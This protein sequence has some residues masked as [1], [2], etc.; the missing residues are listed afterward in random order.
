MAGTLY[1]LDHLISAIRFDIA[2]AAHSAVPEYTSAEYILDARSLVPLHQPRVG[3]Y[4]KGG[5]HDIPSDFASHWTTQDAS[6]DVEAPL[7]ATVE[8]LLSYPDD[9][10]RRI[11][12]RAASRGLVAAIQA[13]D[14]FKYALSNAWGAKDKDGE[15]FSYVC[16]DSV[17]N[18]ER[19]ANGNAR[20]RHKPDAGERLVSRKPTF[21]CKGS[22]GT[23]FSA[24]G[25][26]V[27]VHYRHIAVHEK[28]A[29]QVRRVKSAE[30]RSVGQGDERVESGLLQQLRREEA[31]Y[32]SPPITAAEQRAV[33][34]IQSNTS[35]PLKRKYDAY[36]A[37]PTQQ[38]PRNASLADLLKQDQPNRPASS[39]SGSVAITKPQTTVAYELPSWLP[40]AMPPPPPPRPR[41]MP[42]RDQQM[43]TPAHARQS[44]PS[45]SDAQQHGLD[46]RL[47]LTWHNP[48]SGSLENQ[49]N[50]RWQRKI[51]HTMQAQPRGQGLF[52]TLKSRP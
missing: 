29:L 9:G 52:M 34:P 50:H 36:S 33:P 23:K 22:I 37:P 45:N 12:Q 7:R 15:R 28:A 46:P 43:R 1:S 41:P 40:T 8:A 5:A 51:N 13:V 44:Q 11:V 27:V 14:G 38:T 18:K 2:A 47:S 10:Q 35:R 17:Q 48:S 25:R 20:Y 39:N 42:S 3:L 4:A 49:P 6:G 16:N 19:W 26:C 21:D 31:A 30:P 24:S 32:A